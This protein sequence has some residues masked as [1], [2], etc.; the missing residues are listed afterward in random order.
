MKVE[1]NCAN[2]GSPVS[3][4]WCGECGAAIQVPESK[5]VVEESK[6]AT[7]A[8]TAS[9][10]PAAKAEA[11][12]IIANTLAGNSTADDKF[13]SKPTVIVASSGAS[14]EVKLDSSNPRFIEGS[15]YRLKLAN[16][17]VMKHVLGLWDAGIKSPHMGISITGIYMVMADTS[18]TED[19]V[20]FSM[21][22][23]KDCE[24]AQGYWCPNSEANLTEVLTIGFKATTNL[25]FALDPLDAIRGNVTGPKKVIVAKLVLKNARTVAGKVVLPIGRGACPTYIV[26]YSKN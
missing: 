9:A 14:S 26:N 20:A 17:S 15:N 1:S 18:L 6:P 7:T 19:F 8:S 12:K 16:E 5:P 22:M 4:K 23:G 10:T 21:Q 24:N 13:L 25:S 2:C 3:G 11:S